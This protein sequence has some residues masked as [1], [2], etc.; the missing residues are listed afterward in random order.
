MATHPAMPRRTWLGGLLF[1]QVRPVCALKPSVCVCE[2]VCVCLCLCAAVE[3]AESAVA[4]MPVWCCLLWLTC[5][6]GVVNVQECAKSA[7]PH[8][9]VRLLPVP[10]HSTDSVSARL[11]VEAGTAQRIS[12]DT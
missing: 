8:M 11:I 2:S 6:C 5:L 10:M 7:L 4:H 1:Y 3:C 9:P 12:D